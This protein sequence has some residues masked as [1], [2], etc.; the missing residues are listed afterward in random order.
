MDSFKIAFVKNTFKRKKVFLKDIFRPNFGQK[1]S[2]EKTILR[3]IKILIRKCLSEKQFSCLK[4]SFIKII[5]NESIFQIN[6]TIVMFGPKKKKK[7]I[8]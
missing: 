6:I 5:L 3:N 7:S 4:V 8:F 1:L 2:L